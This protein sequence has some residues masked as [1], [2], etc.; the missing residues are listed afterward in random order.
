MKVNW[1]L[2]VMFFW[3]IDEIFRTGFTRNTNECWLLQ[4]VVTGKYFDQNK[5][6]KKYLVWFD[7]QWHVLPG[8]KCITEVWKP[9]T[10]FI[11]V[12][13]WFVRFTSFCALFIWRSGNVTSIVSITHTVIFS[14]QEVSRRRVAHASP[15]ENKCLWN[16][17]KK[18]QL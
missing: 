15:G 12:C 1:H 11:L 3:E 14:N 8:I 10:M 6:F 9:F 13:T 4:L 16:S 18:K 7:I 2:L 5:F 17:V